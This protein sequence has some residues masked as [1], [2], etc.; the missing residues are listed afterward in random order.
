V[1]ILGVVYLSGN[2]TYPSTLNPHVQM[3]SSAWA[4]R[5]SSEEEPSPLNSPMGGVNSPKPSRHSPLNSSEPSRSPLP[6]SGCLV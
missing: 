2:F 6:H 4:A 3:K 5:P 1:D